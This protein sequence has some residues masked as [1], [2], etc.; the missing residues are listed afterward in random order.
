MRCMVSDV[1][2]AIGLMNEA[3]ATSVFRVERFTRGCAWESSDRYRG[4]SVCLGLNHHAI[5]AAV[6]V[7]L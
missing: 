2:D 6:E 4:R 1:D 5:A 7:Q 3:T